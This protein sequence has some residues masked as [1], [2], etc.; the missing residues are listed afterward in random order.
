MA[1]YI[2]VMV[3]MPVANSVTHPSTNRARHRVT[4]PIRHSTAMLC[5]AI[6]TERQLASE[7]LSDAVAVKPAGDRV[8]WPPFPKVSSLAPH[9]LPHV[10]YAVNLL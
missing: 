1:G 5:D 9:F 8:S 3:Y 4:L 10:V 7:N 6:M 2:T